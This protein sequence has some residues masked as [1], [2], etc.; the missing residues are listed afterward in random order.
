MGKKTKQYKGVPKNDPKKDKTRSN[1]SNKNNVREFNKKIEENQRVYFEKKKV[2][3][4]Y[5]RLYQ[6]FEGLNIDKLS[7]KDLELKAS[8]FDLNP[9][10]NYELLSKLKDKNISEYNKYIIKYKYTLN[11]DDAKILGCFND[12][13]DAIIN[14]SVNNKFEIKEIKSLS[15]IK[16]FNFL[17]YIMNLNFHD[18]QFVED[19]ISYSKIIE[20]NILSY[21]N[22]VELIFKIPNNYG[23]SELQYYTFLGLFIIYFSKKI[24][25]VL[26]EK[27]EDEINDVNE[28]KSN[29]DNKTLP[30]DIFFDWDKNY[31]GK[32]EKIDISR[33]K[34]R[35]SK[36]KESID[37]Y[38]SEIENSLNIKRME[39]DKDN[40]NNKKEQ[41]N[42]AKKEEEEEPVSLNNNDNDKVKKWEMYK[43]FH[44]KH[45]FKLKKY[46]EELFNLF[47]EKDD[48]KIIKNIEFIYYSILFTG[49]K[50]L[51]MY[52][53]YVNSLSYNPNMNNKNFQEN[54]EFFVKSELKKTIKQEELVFSNLDSHFNNKID[55]P[56]SNNAIYY[57]YP[58]LLKKNIFQTNENIYNHFREYLKKIY[59][60][61][62]LQEIFYAT[63][64]F[65]D[66]KYPLLD[67]EILEEMIDNTVFLPYYHDELHGYTQKQ[68]AKVYIATNLSK[69]DFHKGDLSKI[70]IEISH[71][72]NSIIHEQFHH[73]IKGLLF[74]NSFR[75]KK[76]KR[77]NSDV[78]DYK[79]ENF[80]LD[81]I[82]KKYAKNKTEQFTPVVD[83]G[84]RAEIYLYRNIHNKLY[85]GGALSMF[86]I[87]SWKKSILDHLEDF[88]GNNRPLNEIIQLSI[89]EVNNKYNLD[90]FLKQICFQFNKFYKCN[91][92][93]VL[94]FS[95][96]AERSN[97]IYDNIP[98]NDLV[99]DYNLCVETNK[100]E[101]PDT[102]TNENGFY[103]YGQ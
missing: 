62:L 26:D 40:D 99:L 76:E 49:E 43:D 15:K 79:Q 4:S 48:M 41:K 71:I 45:V 55:N 29:Y 73:Y 95:T 19:F 37:K 44:K 42:D 12:D 25:L 75:F 97:Y 82:G 16:L 32:E 94:N 31:K 72:L 100:V 38:I 70:I 6:S 78:S 60:S 24:R 9:K 64:E 1:N 80:Y 35:K 13:I 81:N 87:C 59:Q 96:S 51:N 22:D 86:D 89:D 2:A 65:Q 84:H 103:K 68:F 30:K 92:Q 36:L 53:A 77:L 3:I 63:P 57:K 85:L 67:K 58:F 88:N 93:I 98:N 56:F 90:D 8:H 39:I 27:A 83:E 5:K 46:K 50:S 10:L 74:Y 33:F 52:D 20:K 14:E 7:L 54:Y 21:A 34:E 69:D 17:F 91:N 18:K 102:E 47:K 23:N 28:L 61:D 101:I 11:Y 66:F